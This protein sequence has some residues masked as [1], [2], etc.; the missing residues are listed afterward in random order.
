MA[1]RD[2]P[3]QRKITLLTMLSAVSALLLAGLM[4]YGLEVRNFRA[5]LVEEMESIAALLGANSQAALEFED[6]KAGQQALAVLADDT[7]IIS[8]TV[9]NSSGAVFASYRHPIRSDILENRTSVLGRLEIR[10]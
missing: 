9:Y 10:R 8:A 5:H 1:F 7:R 3:V 6:P 2:L 4:F